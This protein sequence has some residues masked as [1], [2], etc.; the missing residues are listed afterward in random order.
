MGDLYTKAILT[1]IAASLITI[2]LQ[3]SPSADAQTV[4]CGMTIANPCWSISGEVVATSDGA[5]LP[6]G[7][8]Y[9]PCLVNPKSSTF[10]RD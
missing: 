6:F 8:E 4:T 1:V 7:G 5:K 2:A 3:R 10:C 9:R